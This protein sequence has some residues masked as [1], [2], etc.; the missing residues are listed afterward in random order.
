MP[1]LRTSS[2]RRSSG[3]LID[4]IVENMRQNLEELKYATLAPSRYIVSLSAAEFARLEGI[5]PRLQ[6]EAIRALDEELARLNRP[7]WLRRR[8]SWNVRCAMVR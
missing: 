6:A 2:D 5:I 1:Q 8:A 4:A 7:S 3:D